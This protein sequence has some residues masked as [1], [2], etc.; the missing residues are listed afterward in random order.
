MAFNKNTA[1]SMAKRHGCSRIVLGCCNKMGDGF[2][3]EKPFPFVFM[4]VVFDIV[5]PSCGTCATAR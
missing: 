4:Y 2:F 1:V 3:Q 5:D